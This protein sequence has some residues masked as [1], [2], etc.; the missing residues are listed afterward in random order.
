MIG[1]CDE[2]IKPYQ[3]SMKQ[4]DKNQRDLIMFLLNH[5]EKITH[6]CSGKGVNVV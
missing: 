3:E 1:R 2:E 4:N 6:M 5:V